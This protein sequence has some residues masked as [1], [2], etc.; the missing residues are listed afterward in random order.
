MFEINNYHLD[1]LGVFTRY[2]GRARISPA[3]WLEKRLRKVSETA[4]FSSP[5]LLLSSSLASVP[6]RLSNK[7]TGSILIASSWNFGLNPLG[8]LRLR[9]ND[10]FLRSRFRTGTLWRLSNMSCRY[11][12]SS[13]EQLHFGISISSLSESRLGVGDGISLAGSALARVRSML[14][15]LATGLLA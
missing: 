13:F 15:G 5:L 2:L 14:L 9:T 1:K 11:V 12:H 8:K 3:V 6:A 7:S 10:L 4:L